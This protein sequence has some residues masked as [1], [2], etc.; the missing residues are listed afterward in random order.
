MELNRWVKGGI[1][2]SPVWMIC[3]VSI[4]SKP[5]AFRLLREL[6][7]DSTSEVLNWTVSFLRV[8]M[9]LMVSKRAVTSLNHGT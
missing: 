1:N 7:A 8:E 3:S 5:G 6:I 4:L 9:D 2:D